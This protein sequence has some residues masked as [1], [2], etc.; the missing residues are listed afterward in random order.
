[1]LF[2]LTINMTFLNCLFILFVFH[3][4]VWFVSR[5]HLLDLCSYLVSKTC[6]L[7]MLDLSWNKIGPHGAIALG[8]ALRKNASLEEMNVASNSIGDYGGQRLV[9]SLVSHRTLQTFILSQ[10]EIADRTCFVASRVLKDHPSI[11]RLDLTFNPLGEAGARSIYRTILRGLK[12]WVMMGNCSFGENDSIFNST[13]PSVDN[14]YSLD[15]SEPYDAAVLNE[16]LTKLREDPINCS[17]EDM[18]Y[19]EG[20]KSATTPISLTVVN[21]I[22]ALKSTAKAWQPPESGNL[23]F[24]FN[25]AVF[26]PSLLNAID[27]KS[28]D[29]L[30][31]IVEAGKAATRKKDVDKKKVWL[32]FLC[33][34][35]YFT[36]A[37]VQSLVLVL[38]Y[39]SLLRVSAHY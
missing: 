4:I 19:Q 17:F 22:V 33:Q 39:V 13:Y 25:Q 32:R 11:R 5:S 21:G 30:Q 27:A 8:M 18:V 2:P 3:V 23:R 34:D 28:F 31:K 6:V 24:K 1:M 38:L 16:L 26:V 37:Q 14:P 9:S 29:T 36:T 20:S 15:L 7:K 12:C 10:N 35:V